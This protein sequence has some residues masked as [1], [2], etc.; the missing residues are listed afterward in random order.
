MGYKIEPS[1][2]SDVF[3]LPKSVVEKHIKLAGASQ[4]KVL[5]WLFCRGGSCEDPSEISKDTG[6]SSADIADGHYEL[7]TSELENTG[8][9]KWM[10]EHCAEYGFIV[11]YPNG[12]SD[13]TGIIYEPWHFRYV[14]VEA[15][16]YI[17]EN[18]LTLEEFLA[19]YENR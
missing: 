19:L 7:L 8:L 9:Y 5:L 4:L 10:V 16:T 1:A 3:V 12:K 18:D 15:A 14:G 17:M 2:Y 11:R 6:L 13:V